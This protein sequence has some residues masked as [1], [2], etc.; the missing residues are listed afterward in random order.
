MEKRSVG[1][2]FFS[3]V[4]ILTV[5][6]V[7]VKLIGLLYTIPL[8]NM[9]GDEGM[10]YFN[11]AY[12]IYSWLYMFSTAGLPVAMSMM[13]SRFNAEDRQAEKRKL[14]LLTLCIFLTVGLLGSAIMAFCCRGLAGFIAADLSYLCIL[15]V[16]P[17]LFFVCIS[18]T[19]RGYFQGHSNMLPTAISEIL[20]SVGKASLGLFLGGYALKQ[21]LPIYQV[22]AYSIIGVSAGVAAG[23]IFLALA[24]LL[25]KRNG[26]EIN[27][28]ISTKSTVTS[29]EL[30]K[31][32]FAIAVPVMISASL[33][34][35]SS[36]LDT[37]II[38][39]RLID[40]DLAENAAIAMYG[41][42]TAYCVKLFNLPP[43]LI[44]PI[45]NA[46]IP[47]VSSAR[48]KGDGR[49]AERIMQTAL[50][51]SAVISLPCAFGL[52]TLSEPILKLIFKNGAS[53]E[54]AAPLLTALAPSI[55][56]IGVM[57]VSNG[58]LQSC[59]LQKY[60]LISMPA[61]A[62]V[63]AIGAYLLPSLNIGGTPLRMY[64]APISTFAFYTTVTALNFFFIVKYTDL[65]ISVIKVY[66][67]PF[68]ASVIC[69]VAAAGSYLL[70]STPVG[71]KAAVLLA[72]AVAAAVYAVALLILGA[73]S[74]EELEMLPLG[75]K[76][77]PIL[78]SLKL[79]K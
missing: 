70:L 67:R 48:A 47:I 23:A 66:L 11:T 61:G 6:N 56:L 60:T 50:R 42:Y 39:R 2:S 52:A 68:I 26:A 38:I 51:L 78:S 8:T 36:M 73:I 45:V 44:Y 54:M 32:L 28:N 3:G 27:N 19:L 9:L 4:L 53:A 63:K 49:R 12:Q 62:I 75:K 35:M 65:R 37:L 13:I 57:A 24:K 58:I 71:E 34:S 16:S 72:I 20:E 59:G 79:L 29:K 55:F 43:V 22:A 40:T 41:N 76:I 14:L 5:A 33:L 17:A 30:L 74:R 21:G 46:L 18:S 77:S 64:A 25:G 10:G 31:S 69:A 1:R 7:I 15:A